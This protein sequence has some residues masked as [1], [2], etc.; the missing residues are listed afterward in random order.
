M[1]HETER[2][3]LKNRMTQPKKHLNDCS[4]S[5]DPWVVIV[6]KRVANHYHFIDCPTSKRLIVFFTATGAE[7]GAFNF[8]QAAQD[9][10]SDTNV[11]LVNGWS[12]TWYQD[13]VRGLGENIEETLKSIRFYCEER[14][15]TQIFCSGQSM[16]GYGALLF[17]GLLGGKAIAF[18][19]ETVLDLPHSQYSRKANRTVPILYGNLRETFASGLNAVLL[20]GERDPVDIYCAKQLQGL[21]G[22]TIKT[23]RFVGHGPA[24]HLRN[25]KRLIPFLRLIM[26]DK[27]LPKMPEDGCALVRPGFPESFYAGWCAIRD[28][29]FE[30]ARGKLELAVSLYPGSDEARFLLGKALEGLNNFDAALIHYSIAYALAARK[31]ALLGTANC[32]RRTDQLVEAEHVYRKLL[33]I[34]PDEASAHYFLGLCCL[35]LKNKRGAL[36]HLGLAVALAPKNPTYANRLILVQKGITP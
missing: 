23:M 33:S 7:P 27:S 25:R 14:G 20:A 26:A 17:A 36:T 6:P 30:S 21:P 15:I 11:L 5:E 9:I 8:W 13:G 24:G 16:G 18:G 34:W 12:N 32:L 1:F 28:K 22:V 3:L 29:D 35:A 19:A 10:S 2:Y 4:A 31:D